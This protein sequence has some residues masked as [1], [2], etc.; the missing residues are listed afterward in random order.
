MTVLS[1]FERDPELGICA[2]KRLEREASIEA[3]GVRQDPSRNTCRCY[4]LLAP[5]DIPGVHHVHVGSLSQE[6]ERTGRK[7]AHSLFEF[8]P[9]LSEFL[10]P[11]LA[12]SP[13]RPTNDGRDATAILEESALIDRLQANIGEP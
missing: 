1:A 4:G 7:M 13:C 10:R 5:L 9:S 12:C 3:A 11:D 8:L 6:R 2:H